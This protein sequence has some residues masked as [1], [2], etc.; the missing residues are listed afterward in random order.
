MGLGYNPYH[1]SVFWDEDENVVHF[2]HPLPSGTKKED[3]KVEIDEDGK[4]LIKISKGVSSHSD[5]L[6]SVSSS[7]I[8]FGSSFLSFPKKNEGETASPIISMKFNLP[9]GLDPNDS[10]TAIDDEGLL[11]LTFQK[12]VPIHC[13]TPFA[14]ENVPEKWENAKVNHKD[15]VRF[16]AYLGA[17]TKREDMMVGIGGCNSLMIGIHDLWKKEEGATSTLM[18]LN[19]NNFR[20]FSLPV[21]VNPNS[22]ETAVDD[23]GVLTVTVTKLKPEKKKLM[24]IAKKMLVCLA[25]AVPT[26]LVIGYKI[27][28]AMSSGD[29]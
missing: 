12:L 10:N 16:K 21:G 14:L 7:L 11:T 23:A 20:S 25:Q 9:A 29:Y 26:C 13:E 2:K 18:W 6:S 17:G 5:L 27:D 15:V 19:D 1:C 8:S 22:L 28:D 3:V 24:S 4:L